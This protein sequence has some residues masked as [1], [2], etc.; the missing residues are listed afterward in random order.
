MSFSGL[1]VH[2]RS[3]EGLYISLFHFQ[4]VRCPLADAGK[5]R[6]LLWNFS[7]VQS[8]Y[9]RLS[10][11]HSVLVSASGARS[12]CWRATA[13]ITPAQMLMCGKVTHKN[14][15]DSSPLFRKNIISKPSR[16]SQRQVNG[17]SPTVDS[18]VCPCWWIIKGRQQKVLP[19]FPII[20]ERER[21]HD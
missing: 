8:R 5:R 20:K 15:I 6:N 16:A 1:Q 3:G 14:L 13:T 17:L 18:P 9:C 21:L 4:T 2:L 7:T 11:S 19:P 10:S 12:I